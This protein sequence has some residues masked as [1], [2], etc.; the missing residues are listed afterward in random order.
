MFYIYYTKFLHFSAIQ[1]G[2]F[3]GDTSWSMCTAYMA[4]YFSFFLITVFLEVLIS[5]VL[6]FFNLNLQFIQS[7]LNE[8]NM[9]EPHAF[10]YAAVL[11][12]VLI[13]I[14]F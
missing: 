3:Q 12:I 5:Q 8:E 4:Q 1:H 10:G 9:P 11:S 7:S 14:T 2:H 6:I 13:S